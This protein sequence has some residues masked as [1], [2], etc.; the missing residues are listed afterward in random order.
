MKLGR[1]SSD[2]AFIVTV[3]HQWGHSVVTQPAGMDRVRDEG[4]AKCMHL[5]K[6]RQPWD[7]DTKGEGPLS[8]REI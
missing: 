2:E 4:V 6:G 8:E 5:Q 3:G 7:K 1:L